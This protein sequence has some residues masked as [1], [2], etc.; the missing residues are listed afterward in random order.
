MVFQKSGEIPHIPGD[1]VKPTIVAGVNA[2]GR[3]QDRESLIQFMTT[4]AQAMGPE[5]MMQY[6]NP[7]EAIKRLA[8]AQGI[9][10]LN[11]VRSMQEIQAE[12]QANEEKAMSM[13]REE[14]QVQAMK[15]PMADP[16][17]NPQLAQQLTEAP[18]QGTPQPVDLPTN[19]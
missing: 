14:L 6:I 5:A 10:I 17:K 18:G 4:I 15:S 2:L 3:G 7:E 13:K 8:A 19:N 9:D 11:L 12:Q 16:T 1:M